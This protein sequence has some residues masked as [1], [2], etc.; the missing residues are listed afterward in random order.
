MKDALAFLETAFGLA[1][2]E[3]LPETSVEVYRWRGD[4]VRFPVDEAGEPTALIHEALQDSDWRPLH[5]G[6]PVFRGFDGTVTPWADEEEVYPVFIGE[7]AY[8]TAPP[9]LG[10]N[11]KIAFFPCRREQLAVPAWRNSVA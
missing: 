2:E 3:C 6:D 1:S 5:S 10:N 11:A 4:V 7:C 9:P 8:C